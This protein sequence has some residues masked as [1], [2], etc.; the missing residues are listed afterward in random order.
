[1]H[2]ISQKRQANNISFLSV[3]VVLTLL[4]CQVSLIRHALTIKKQ[5]AF[6]SI[7]STSYGE[8]PS[9]RPLN[10]SYLH[11]RD[12]P[13][14]ISGDSATDANQAKQSKMTTSSDLDSN[15]NTSSSSTSSRTETTDRI[16]TSD[17]FKSSIDETNTVPSSTRAN[18]Q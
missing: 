2:T 13:T 4:V 15:S 7:V 8:R 6:V 9:Q 11:E 17:A 14:V 3:V 16:S 12:T 1:M 10:T 18:E 5:F